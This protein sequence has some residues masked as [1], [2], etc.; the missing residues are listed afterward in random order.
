MGD[1]FSG[2]PNLC[3][4]GKV[5]LQNLLPL[6]PRDWKENGVLPKPVALA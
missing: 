3:Q 1:D 6:A 2:S 4:F 5:C